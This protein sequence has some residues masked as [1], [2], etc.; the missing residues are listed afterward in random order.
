MICDVSAGQQYY[1]KE[2]LL[3][4]MKNVMVL[5]LATPLRQSTHIPN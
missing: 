4:A 1:G 2:K 5:N 3:Q